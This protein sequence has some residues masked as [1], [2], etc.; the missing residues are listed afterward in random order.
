[1]KPKLKKYKERDRRRPNQNSPSK[2]YQTGGKFWETF[3]EDQKYCGGHK[4][5]GKYHRMFSRILRA[6]EK[7]ETRKE[8]EDSE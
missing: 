7:I 8:I 2:R 1:M 5:N 3:L 6:Q 4:S